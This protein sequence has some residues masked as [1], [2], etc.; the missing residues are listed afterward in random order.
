MIR[1]K[2]LCC[3]AVGLLL[4]HIP[5]VGAGLFAPYAAK[6]QNRDVAFAPPT[7]IHLVD[8][9]G[10]FHL[11][12]F[13]CRWVSAAGSPGSEAS[14]EDCSHTSSLRFLVHD[15]TVY[16]G[17]TRGA[18]WHLFATDGPEGIFLL[19]TDEYGRD[20]FSRLLY[21][22]QTSVGAGLLATV[23]S[24]LLGLLLGSVAGYFG[25]WADDVIM[26]M[27]E[28]FMALPWIY[29]LFAVRAFLPLRL[30]SRQAFL[31]LIGVIGLVGWA[32]P[33]RLIRGVILSAKQRNYVLA[34]RGFGISDVT[35][36]RRHILPEVSSVVLTQAALLI[37]QCML[38]EVTLSFLG[39]GVGEP[40]P[41]WGNMLAGLESYYALTTHSWM[42]ASALVLLPIFFLLYL[43]ADSLQQ[44]FQVLGPVNSP[45]FR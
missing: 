42:W 40:Q 8:A 22:G 44:H 28:L 19:G 13:V 20:Q 23:L 27:A 21:G 41:S 5:I 17:K 33:A 1:N 16:G 15:G 29:L 7:P 30:D 34:A 11:R 39:L 12:P 2:R 32:R 25:F 18:A 6:T 31:V 45:Y 38:A 35:I 9:R 43:F 26:R 10:H 24:L 14:H 3:S 4:L 37:P 36:L